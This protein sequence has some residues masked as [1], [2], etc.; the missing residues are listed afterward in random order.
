LNRTLKQLAFSVHKIA[1][2]YPGLA[3]RYLQLFRIAKYLPD[4]AWKNYLLNSLQSVEWPRVSLPPARVSLGPSV[5]VS[6]IPHLKE[7]DFSA[8]LYRRMK[9]E[10][11]VVSWLSGRVY[12][13]VLEIGANVGIYS[14][15]FSLMFP[16]ALIYCFEPSRTAYRRLLENLSLN[17]CRNVHAFNCAVAAKSGFLDFYEPEGHLTNGS[18]DESFARMFSDSVQSAK[19]ATIGGAEV[20]QL[21]PPG[22]RVL[23]KIDVEGAEPIVLQSLSP[24]I[25]RERPDILMEVLPATVEALNRIDA[26]S[27]YRLYQLEPN[28]PCRR[29]FFVVGEN[30]DYA[31]TPRLGDAGDFGVAC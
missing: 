11:E 19:V 12:D 20:S 27:A 25:T 1:A 15:L 30:R 2:I 6:I 10:R 14:L 3:S 18:L 8:H 31:L 16:N 17:D 7:F 28:G 23:L 24:F 13:V 26:L 9:Y 29:D 21:I 4:G 5:V 22:K